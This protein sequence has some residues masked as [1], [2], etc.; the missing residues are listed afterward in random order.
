[1]KGRAR[2]ALQVALRRC[3]QS[4][5]KG[6]EPTNQVSLHGKRGSGSRR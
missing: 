3:K 5:M 1:M 2:A 4:H 6:P